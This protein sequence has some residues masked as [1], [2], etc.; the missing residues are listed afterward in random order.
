M[1]GVLPLL[2]IASASAAEPAATQLAC[3]PSAPDQIT[4]CG[5]RNGESPYR[6]PKT[7]KDYAPKPLP[8]AEVHL[9]EGVTANAHAESQV[10]PDGK[11][12]K[13]LMLTVKI[14]F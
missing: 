8:K 3:G 5:T 14:K 10:M 11:A 12:G 13:A 7:A 4:V 2:F 9:A 1:I 6:L